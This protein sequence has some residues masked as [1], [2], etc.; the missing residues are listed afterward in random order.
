MKPGPIDYDPQPAK[1]PVSFVELLYEINRGHYEA[2]K[3]Y[4]IQNKITD[5]NLNQKSHL[6]DFNHLGCA[7]KD[8]AITTLKLRLNHIDNH[9]AENLGPALK[10]SAITSLDI[11]INNIG[12]DGAEKLI[13]YLK[14]TSV[15]ILQVSY[16]NIGDEGIDKLGHAL[17][18]TS[19][20]FLNLRGNY[21]SDDGAAIL[22]A[23]IPDTLLMNVILE[24]EHND[25]KQA[26]ALNER[27][28][29]HAPYTAMC[30]T[31]LLPHLLP[32][33]SNGKKNEYINAPALNDNASKENE[34]KFIVGIFACLGTNNPDLQ[35][36]IM[37]YLPLMNI[38]R[39]QALQALAEEHHGKGLIE[40]TAN[41]KFQPL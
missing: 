39:T 18:G 14:D 5:L 9:G 15:N 30:L 38:K 21:I 16:N 33:L 36:S 19:V 10:G 41:K 17:K 1:T 3:A 40:I 2:F 24:F 29:I 7:L 20:T 28:L 31:P 25:L 4:L 23:G 35:A 37:N 8:T 27:K 12:D 34:I 13:N 11:A 32:R 6:V 26:L 22:A